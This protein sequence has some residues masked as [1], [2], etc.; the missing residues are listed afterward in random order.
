MMVKILLFPIELLGRIGDFKMDL[1]CWLRTWGSI[2]IFVVWDLKKNHY[3]SSIVQSHTGIKFVGS[4]FGRYKGC[5]KR[6]GRRKER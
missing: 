5:D 2:G 1:E 3:L 6:M 4:D